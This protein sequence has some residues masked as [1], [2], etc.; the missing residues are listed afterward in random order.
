MLAAALVAYVRRVFGFGTATC[1]AAA[2]LLPT[3]SN[4]DVT[5][6]I[7]RAGLNYRF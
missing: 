5:A 3:D 4:A 2:C 1:D 6:N 7:F